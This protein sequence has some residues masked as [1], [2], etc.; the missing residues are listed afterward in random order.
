MPRNILQDKQTVRGF[1]GGGERSEIN[2]EQFCFCINIHVILTILFLFQ[3][4][5]FRI[6]SYQCISF[7][8][9]KMSLKYCAISKLFNVVI[10]YVFPV[11]P[12][13]KVVFRINCINIIS[14]PLSS[15]PICV[16]GRVCE[17]L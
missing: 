14:V 16:G 7:F 10:T 5:L 2:E 6:I 4:V 15:T 11:V 9:I 1:G 17:I 3:F 12:N 13:K 8:V